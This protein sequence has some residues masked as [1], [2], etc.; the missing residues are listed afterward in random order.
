MS[1]PW[2]TLKS[3]AM[4]A[5]SSKLVSAPA[6][7]FCEIDSSFSAASGDCRPTKAVSTAR[8]FGNSFSVAAVMMPSVPSAPMNRLRRS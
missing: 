3:T 2:R 7:S 4:S 5:S 1:M 8:G 6:A